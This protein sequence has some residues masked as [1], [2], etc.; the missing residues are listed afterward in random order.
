MVKIRQR[1]IEGRPVSGQEARRTPL[2]SDCAA[3]LVQNA[4]RRAADKT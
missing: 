2:H 3:R 1:Y 4:R